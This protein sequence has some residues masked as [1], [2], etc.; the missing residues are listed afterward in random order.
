MIVIFSETC[1]NQTQNLV[2]QS[3]VFKHICS[4]VELNQTANLNIFSY[5]RKKTIKTDAA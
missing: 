1:N 3:S 5:C 4:N 2:R